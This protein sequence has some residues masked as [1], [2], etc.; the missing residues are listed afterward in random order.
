MGNDEADEADR[1]GK[2]DRGTDGGRHGD[3]REA[4]QR[5]HGDPEVPCLGL[6]ERDRIEPRRDQHCDDCSDHDKGQERGEL[7]PGRPGKAAKHPEIDVPE[8]LIIAHVDEETDQSSR[9]R[10]QGDAGKQHGRNR[11]PAA[12]GRH[13]VEDDGDDQRSGEG[14]DREAEVAEGCGEARKHAPTQHD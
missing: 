3:D 13:H 5:L 12:S 6:A 10:R 11:R 2:R 9:N 8:L 1:A 14:E 7:H 4:L